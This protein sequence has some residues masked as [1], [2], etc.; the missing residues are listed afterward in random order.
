[1][2][3]I[4]GAAVVA[5]VDILVFEVADTRFGVD[6]S[7]VVRI[8]MPLED[9]AVG[10]PLGTPKKGRRAL[11][12][13]GPDGSQRRLTI[14]LVHGIK[15]IALDQ[16]RRLPPAAQHGQMNIGAWL[17]GDRAVVL[18]DLVSMVSDVS[19]LPRGTAH[20]E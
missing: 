15:S 5:T 20:V 1:M 2:S 11:V 6:A 13:E 3:P 4:R 10:A 9:E 16:L 7:Q 8:D 18:V 19:L 17:D 12:F 14:D